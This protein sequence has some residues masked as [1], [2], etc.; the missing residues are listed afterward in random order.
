MYFRY[1]RL[2]KNN[3]LFHVV[4]WNSSGATNSAPVMK[5][6][7]YQ[8]DAIDAIL[9]SVKRGIRR[10]SIVL[11]TGGGKT[12]VFSH[13]V[14]QLQPT[15]PE[16]GNKTLVLAHKEELVNQSA[17]MLALV[18]PNLKVAIDM[19]K[20]KPD[21]DSDIIVGS[22]PTLIRM[23][24]LE[25]YNPLEFKTIILDE[26]HH[27]TATSWI[28]ILKYFGADAAEL[29]I[30]VIGFTATMERSDG[31]SLG[32]IFDEVTYERSLIEMVKNKELVDV[33]FST[34]G[35]DLNLGGVKMRFND[36]EATSLSKAINH[37]KTNL[38]IAS[39]Y[40]ELKKRYDF[41]ST[42][43]FCVDI[44]HCKTLCGVLQEQGINAQY[45]TGDT[46]KHERQS[47]IEDFKN[48]KIE[49]LCN[50]QVFTEGTDIPNIDSL[51]LARP[52]KSRTLLV[53]MIGRG[54]RLHKD[55]TVCHVVDIADTRNTG[56]QSVPTL[57]D[58]P[59]DYVIENKTYAEILEEKQKILEE[60]RLARAMERLKLEEATQQSLEKIRQN[61]AKGK[62]DFK[63]ID[64]FLA[65]ED[66]TASQ[67]KD[68]KLVR[69]AFKKSRLNW[70]RLDY[71]L[72]GY[73]HGVT[74]FYLIERS[75]RDGRSLFQLSLH[76]FTSRFT[77]VESRF[78]APK[79]YLTRM[80]DFETNLGA[81]ITNVELLEGQTQRFRL[82]AA[83][84]RTITLKQKSFI[85]DKV[86]STIKHMYGQDRLD[87]LKENLEDFNQERAARLIFAIKYSIKS[88]WVRWELLS[89]LGPDK[90]V[91]K[92][93]ESVLDLE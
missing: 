60:E 42:L 76:A 51:F 48:G 62:F 82:G 16:R 90:K 11:A 21:A 59:G 32:T 36:Y 28:K 10:P 80:Y 66:Y 7:D 72:W 56:V 68:I 41:K 17:K 39:S 89:L 5:L 37:V 27:A 30:Y 63:T 12:V 14:S 55:K 53:Q 31:K 57:F 26:C 34:L 86:K 58:L 93:I 47:I 4:R 84:E 33:K 91:N 71:N 77:L 87:E 35:V 19:R 64:G 18:N 15:S 13:L 46:V 54:L 8:Q 24:R 1:A 65:L 85:A 52:T 23:S 88:L 43:M 2:L 29:P 83:K 67:F 81:L 75:E 9:A 44:N 20:L 74:E 40:L 25:K 22:V 6:R 45:V 49:V 38:L 92:T 50:V 3:T 61:F 70:V 78:K 73:P 79:T 69:E